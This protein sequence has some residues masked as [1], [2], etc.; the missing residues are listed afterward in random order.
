M[1]KL[2]ESEL[3]AFV[4][5]Q[6]DPQR[7]AEIARRLA[8]DPEATAR[9][10]EYRRQNEALHALFDPVLEAPI[11]AAM[12][13]P[14]PRRS[15]WLRHAA[16]IG[17]LAVG[18]TIGYTMRGLTPAPAATPVALPRQAALAHVVYAPEVLHPVEVTAAQEQHLVNWLSK[19]LGGKVRAPNLTAAGFE[20][21]GGRLLPGD[22]APA[23]Q[24]MYQD[25]H[26][27]R[28]TLYVRQMPNQDGAAFRF[29][30]ENGVG[31]FYWTD[32]G[33]GYALSGEQAKP[34]LLQVAELV[35][36]QLNP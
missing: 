17:I 21:M 25:A 18:V 28:L 30:E 6:L 4:D 31:V 19:R 29:A 1:S 13:T 32:R 10:A 35:Y 5:G 8:E 24:F 9:V 2:N 15:A 22:G 12:Q 7:E 14:S 20:L 36:R 34:E 3:H 11:P 33:F 23:A 27:H 16:M 26:G